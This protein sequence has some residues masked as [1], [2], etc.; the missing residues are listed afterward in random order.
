M[1]T[2]DLL[3]T[4]KKI[5][6]KEGDIIFKEEEDGGGQMYFI[7]TGRITILKKV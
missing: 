6:F 3:Y 7:D 5:V 2:K 1:S 4:K